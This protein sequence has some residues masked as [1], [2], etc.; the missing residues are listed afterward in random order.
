MEKTIL[1]IDD[2]INVRKMLSILIK[3]NDLGKVV[4]ELKSG[5]SAVQEILFYNPDIILIDLLLP[6]MDGLEIIKSSKEKGYTGKFIMISQVEK[7]EL[8]SKAYECGALFF[9][10]K[11][12]NNIEVIN[13]IKGVCYNIELEKSLTLIKSAVFNMN[14]FKIAIEPINI[15]NQLTKIFTDIG[16]VGVVGSSDL[17]K[18]II[19]IIKLKSFQNC[20]S[21]HLQDIYE[22]IVKDESGEE[23]LYSNKK[24]FEQRI[25]RTIQKSFQTIAELGADDYSSGIFLEYSTVLFDFSQI[26]QQMRYIENYKEEQG[27]I[28][29]KKF[30]EG[31]ISKLNF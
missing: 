5:D 28:N 17:R 1:I 6:V 7:E 20:Y 10:S 24:T 9:I 22:K 19:N 25:R 27:K 4:G 16:I 18:V 11:P 29:I 12:I 3:K 31:I 26:R 21:Y 23:N 14:D 30:I 8:V 15:E 13:V 2:D